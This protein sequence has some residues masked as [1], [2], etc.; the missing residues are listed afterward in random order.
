MVRLASIIAVR[1][2][3]TLVNTAML[4]NWRTARAKTAGWVETRVHNPV[5]FADFI[6]AGREHIDARLQ[7][8]LLASPP[9]AL[10]TAPNR[11][12]SI[13]SATSA[14]IVGVATMCG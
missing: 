4:I 10:P 3:A 2:S 1:N 7:Q 9:F 8:Y 13:V 6:R 11:T 14:V 5:G 12:V